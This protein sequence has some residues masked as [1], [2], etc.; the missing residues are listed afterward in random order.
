M[1]L[2]KQLL[3]KRTSVPKSVRAL[4]ECRSRERTRPTST[5]IL[6]ALES[7]AAKYSRVL[8]IVDALDECGDSDGERQKFLSAIFN[9]Q[10][11]TEA[12][13]FVTS[14]INDKI[15]KL[16]NT[17]LSLQIYA[18]IG[19]VKSY[20]D[21]QMSLLQSDIL[22]DDLRDSIRREVVRAVDGMYATLSIK[23]C[24]NPF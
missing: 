12:N 22:D 5:E 10:S 14:R 17:A 18:N 13:I 23:Y 1:S 24:R 9:L 21:G 20:L 8:I 15:A 3:E 2:L 6:N 16:F 11:K 7:V 4:Y 19:D